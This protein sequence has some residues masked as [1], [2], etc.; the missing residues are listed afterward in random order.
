MVEPF[1]E[2]DE[3]AKDIPISLGSASESGFGCASTCRLLDGV[4]S[5]RVAR[6]LTGV[7]F[8]SDRVSRRRMDRVIRR[9]ERERQGLRADREAIGGLRMRWTAVA[10]SEPVPGSLE[11]RDDPLTLASL[12][13]GRRE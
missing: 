11:L 1:D 3:R 10:V 6:A 8:G 7:S 9:A 12:K 2:V 13:L 4:V 5:V